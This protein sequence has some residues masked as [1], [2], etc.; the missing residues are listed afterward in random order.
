LGSN[1]LRDYYGRF[2]ITFPLV[3]QFLG[4]G[5]TADPED[6]NGDNNVDAVDVQLVINDALNILTG[7]DSDIN[8]DSVVDA[9][10][11]QLVINAAL[12]L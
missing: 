5:S 4:Q 1:Q 12:G 2:D 8:N 7:L 3:E 9:V 10:D 6:I 11:V